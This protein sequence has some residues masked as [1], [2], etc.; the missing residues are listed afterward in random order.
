M[1]ELLSVIGGDGDLAN[2]LRFV[3]IM[4]VIVLGFVRTNGKV[5]RTK[6]SADLAAARSL[7]TSN[8]YTRRTERMLGK[9]DRRLARVEQDI[10][11]HRAEHRQDAS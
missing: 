9:L 8:G 11:E 5:G 2:V 1:T 3:I 6:D 7:P 10:K 4:T